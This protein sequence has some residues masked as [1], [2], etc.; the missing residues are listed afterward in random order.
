MVIVINSE[1]NN[2][3]GAFVSSNILSC[4][5]GHDK[6]TAVITNANETLCTHHRDDAYLSKASIPID[7]GIVQDLLTQ[8]FPPMSSITKI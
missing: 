1:L 5:R 3:F 8:P 4:A 6:V 7:V 2:S